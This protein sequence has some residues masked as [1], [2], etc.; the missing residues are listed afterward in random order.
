MK[1]IIATLLIAG[2]LFSCS[3]KTAPTTATTTTTTTTTTTAT[4]PPVKTE[5][6]EV[7][8]GKSI[9]VTKCTRC[10][11]AK[12]MDHWTAQQW[13]PILDDM[14]RKARLDDTEKSNVRAYVNFYAKS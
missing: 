9:Y 3:P 10:H 4:T 5:T 7:S 1:S 8:A 2:F 14:A 12:P 13:V 11:E 6:A